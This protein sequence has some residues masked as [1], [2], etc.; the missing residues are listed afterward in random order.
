MNVHTTEKLIEKAKKLAQDILRVEGEIQKILENN[1]S[2]FDV[3]H[4]ED[5]GWVVQTGFCQMGGCLA[6]YVPV[7]SE[8]EAK[9]LAAKMT[10]LGQKP[11]AYGLCHEC[12][13]DLY[14]MEM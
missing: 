6:E 1:E 7:E 3:F 12:R 13:H 11:N 4:L 8:A 9:L 10:F 5:E 2:A 14:E